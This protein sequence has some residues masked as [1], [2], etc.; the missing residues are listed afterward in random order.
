MVCPDLKMHRRVEGK[1]KRQLGLEGS[2]K[3]Q[4]V[5]ETIAMTDLRIQEVHPLDCGSHFLL[6]I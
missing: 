2:T 3:R 4:I 6:R 1:Q 5:Y